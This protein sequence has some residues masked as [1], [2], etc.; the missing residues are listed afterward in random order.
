MHDVNLKGNVM[1]RGVPVDEYIKNMISV[2]EPSDCPC[3]GLTADE[4]EDLVAQTVAK[5]LASF[6]DEKKVLSD[7]LKSV[8][9]KIHGV[10]SKLDDLVTKV[11]D[12]K[13]KRGVDQAT[14]ESSVDRL[15]SE[16][17]ELLQELRS[18]LLE[19]DEEEN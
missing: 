1:I 18:E 3:Q 17:K 13:P 14:L 4:V 15:R 6:Q 11:A 7:S 2:A 16:V 8:S 5:S 19:L 9:E 10:E 12:M